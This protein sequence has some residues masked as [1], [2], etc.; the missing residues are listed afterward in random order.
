MERL[1]QMNQVWF[2]VIQIPGE[3]SLKIKMVGMDEVEKNAGILWK[4]SYQRHS[5]FAGWSIPSLILSLFLAI[6]SL[7]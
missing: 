3:D 5:D 4:K 1:R 6:L 2:L 7:H